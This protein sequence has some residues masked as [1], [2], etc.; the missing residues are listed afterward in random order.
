L[1]EFLKIFENKEARGHCA[2]GSPQAG[3][4]FA[5]VQRRCLLKLKRCRKEN[6]H[7]RI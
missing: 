2:L 6:E 1:L 3:S 5:L 4:V 7:N